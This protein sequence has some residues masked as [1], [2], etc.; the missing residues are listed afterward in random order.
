MTSIT[1]CRVCSG[2]KLTPVLDLG[3]QPHAGLFLTKAQCGHEAKYPLRVVF[4]QDCKTA[5]LDYT[6]PKE[7]LFAQHSYLSGTTETLRQHFAAVAHD[8]HEKFGGS[9]VLDI[10]GNDGTQLLEYKK[11]GYDVLNVEPNDASAVVAEASG[12]K[13]LRKFF[14]EETAQEINS[15]FD[16]I[17][18]SGVF[19][20]L[21][22]LHGVCDGIRKCLAQDGVFVVQFIYAKS[23]I[24]RGAFDQVYHEH[25]LYYTLRSIGAL[26]MMHGLCM[27]DAYKSPIHG[28]SIIGYVGHAGG[29]HVRSDAFWILWEEEQV[30]EWNTP[31]VWERL[32]ARVNV[33]R[34]SEMGRL[35]VA[36]LD[37]KRIHGMGAPVKGNTLLNTLGIGRDLMECLVERNP[38]RRGLYA[39]GSHIPIRME[40]EVDTPDIY[41]FLSWNFKDEIIKRYKGCGAEFWFPVEAA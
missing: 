17:N 24:E 35:R 36:R 21:E 11:L 5:Q 15:E 39:P 41:Y 1:S 10:G 40:N 2:S 16:V 19:F 28:G 9:S 18:A 4:C 37:G 7:A 38:S 22:D 32:V 6:V 8:V 25:L 27:F 26:L 34:L 14:S 13:T 20:H 12:I 33:M 30:F 23:M 29:E 31:E 3:E